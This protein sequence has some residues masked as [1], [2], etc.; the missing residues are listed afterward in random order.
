MKINDK[1]KEPIKTL[2]AGN[3]EVYVFGTRKEM[4]RAAYERYVDRAQ[5]YINKKGKMRAIFAAAHSQD[6][7]LEYLAAD[8]S[9]DFTKIEAFHMDEYFGLAADAPQKFGHFLSERIF[10]LKPFAKVNL[11]DSTQTD[12]LAECA[13]YSALLKDAPIDITSMG[14]GENGHIAFNDPHEARF[15]D[16]QVM[17]TTTLDTVCR[18]QQVHDGEFA[19]LDEVPESAYTLTIPTLMGSGSLVCIV[20]GEQ[21][22]RAV[23]GAIFGPVSTGCPASILKEH[24]DAALFVDKAAAKYIL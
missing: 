14:I 7:F 11:I 16:P 5:K 12:L 15:D 17:R 20:P 22:A 2:K 13:R 24:P 4:A 19:S 1:M 8:N 23:E 21:K 6:E 10:D 9:L 18:M 3:L